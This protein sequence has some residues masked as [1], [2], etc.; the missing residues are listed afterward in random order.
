MNSYCKFNHVDYK[1]V[2]IK[3]KIVGNLHLQNK[4]LAIISPDI[5]KSHMFRKFIEQFA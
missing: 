2:M 1:F 5:V 4:I 3:A